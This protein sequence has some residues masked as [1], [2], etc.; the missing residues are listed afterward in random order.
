[1]QLLAKMIEIGQIQL[2]FFCL[3]R[4]RGMVR[5]DMA[6]STLVLVTGF[7]RMYIY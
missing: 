7:T 2:K 6:L 3:K 4:G 5:K 1:M